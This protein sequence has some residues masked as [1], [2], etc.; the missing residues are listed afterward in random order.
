MQVTLDIDLET[1]KDVL[2]DYFGITLPDDVLLDIIVSNGQLLGEVVDG[3]IRDTMARDTLIYAV[4][5]KIGA[6]DWPT[7]GG[8]AN[9]EEFYADLAS[10]LTAVNGTL[11][12]EEDDEYAGH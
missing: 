3:S 11:E 10:K 4:T 2:L 8:K 5:K 7:Y 6:R 9:M 12:K 1:T